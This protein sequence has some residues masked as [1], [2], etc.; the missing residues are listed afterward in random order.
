MRTL[1]FSLF[2]LIA[3]LAFACSPTRT[4]VDTKAED[5]ALTVPAGVDSLTAAEAKKLADESFVSMDEELRAER[6]KEQA[7]AYRAESDTLWHYLELEHADEHD[8]SDRDNLEAIEAFNEAAEYVRDIDAL[9]RRDDIEDNQMLRE[10]SRLVDQAINSFEE[11]LRLNPF[12]SEVRL[13]L[14]QLYGIKASRLN[15]QQEHEKAIDV[16]E[17]LVRLEKGEHVVYYALAEN[18]FSLENY[19]V[20]AENF[21]RAIRTLQDV[22]TLSDH[23]AEHGAMSRRDSTNLFIYTYYK[24]VSH[25]HL[26]DTPTAMA[27]FDEAM[28][29]AQTEEDKE[30]VQSE[31]DFINWDSGNI[32]ASLEREYIINEL[33]NQGRLEEAE[34]RFAELKGT[35]RSRT[36]RDEID[37]RLGVVEYQNGKEEQAAERLLQ[38]VKRSETNSRGLPVDPD[39]MRYFNDY[40]LICFNLGQ[41]NLNE[42]DRRNALK[43]FMQSSKINWRNRARANLQIA[44]ILSN[45]VEES[46]RY[47]NLAEEESNTLNDQDRLA[48]YSLLTDLHR[49]NGDMDEARRYHQIWR[50]I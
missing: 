29:L 5:E 48:L 10:Y 45:N 23:Y 26:Y 49:R 28:T 21:E 38:L 19:K 6:L 18:Y 15:E 37:W 41:S 32:R 39:H 9:Q 17:K 25:L 12:D 44:N 47:A 20:A 2:I 8:V 43:Y 11:A 31:I 40:G 46:I 35:L 24:G 14:G 22:V 36:A 30:T 34:Q 13:W 16:L 33:V 1:T 7:Q 3:L 50:G 42:R 27:V 4:A